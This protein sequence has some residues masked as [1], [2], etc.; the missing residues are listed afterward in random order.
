M[1]LLLTD[2][3]CNPSLLGIIGLNSTSPAGQGHVVQWWDAQGIVG[4]ILF[5][6]CVLYSSIRNSSNAQVNKLTLTSDESALIEEG[7][8]ADSFEEGGVNRAVDNEKDGVTYSYSFFHFM[9]FLASLY[10]MMTLTNWYSPDSNYEAMTS[11]WPSVWV[12]ISSSWICIAL[13]V[14]TLV[15]PLVLVNRDFD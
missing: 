1:L 13:Y 8:Q 7:P 10:I 6:M 4:L 3:K 12:K 14:W 11:K 15:A 5:L 2:R 9:L